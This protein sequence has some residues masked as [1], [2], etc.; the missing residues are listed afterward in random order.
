MC[1]CDII[2]TIEHQ[3]KENPFGILLFLFIGKEKNMSCIVLK[4][5]E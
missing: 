3:V 4:S 2:S 1:V 5:S